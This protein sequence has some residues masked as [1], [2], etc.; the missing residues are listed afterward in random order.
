M[1][2]DKAW[3]IIAL[4]YDVVTNDFLDLWSL[5]HAMA[6]KV[7]QKLEDQLNCSVCL[8]I[9]KKPK[10][11]QCFHVYCQ[12]C[13]V[14]LVDQD[15]LGHP[16]LSCPTCRQVTAVPTSGVGGLPA[17]FH[18]DQLLEIQDSLKNTLSA[19]VESNASKGIVCS[20]HIEAFLQDM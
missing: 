3:S 4:Y 19:K 2:H 16:F 18:I 7:L 17:A 14:Q 5:F 9:Y 15:Q 6:D 12:K 11:L 10:L 20:E 8:D 1:W 13:L